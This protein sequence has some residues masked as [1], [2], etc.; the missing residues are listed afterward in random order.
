ML[1]NI[2]EALH[3]VAAQL[4]YGNILATLALLRKE[5]EY[6]VNEQR[7]MEAQ[8]EFTGRRNETI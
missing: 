5:R 1:N 3:A 2:A 4:Y 6:T 7:W 8:V